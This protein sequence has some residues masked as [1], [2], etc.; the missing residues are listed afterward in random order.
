MIQ[1]KRP[2]RASAA[3]FALFSSDAQSLTYCTAGL[4]A[5]KQSIQLHVVHISI[6]SPS[7]NTGSRSVPQNITVYHR[8]HTSYI[9][10]YIRSN[11]SL[12][13]DYLIQKLYKPPLCTNSDVMLWVVTYCPHTPSPGRTREVPSTSRYTILY[14]TTTLQTK[15]LVMSYYLYLPSHFHLIFRSI[16]PA[17]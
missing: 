4:F 1:A 9:H 7:S 5:L 15:P 12:H 6:P 17:R 16:C 3:P 14:T 13:T 11:K 2:L 8:P 10:T